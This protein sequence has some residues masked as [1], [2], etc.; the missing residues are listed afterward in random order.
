MTCTIEIIN[1]ID[2][3]ADAVARALVKANQYLPT[4]NTI[5]IL[6]APRVPAD[7]PAYKHPGWLEYPIQIRFDNGSKLFLAMIQ[8][9]IDA[10][11]EFH[12]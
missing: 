11:F 1:K 8:R 5:R 12:S 3:E 4:A 6:C 10:E 7:A 9:T 2:G